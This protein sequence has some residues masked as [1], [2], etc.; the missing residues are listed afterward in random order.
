MICEASWR[1]TGGAFSDGRPLFSRI[2]T[3]YLFR[4]SS[5]QYAAAAARGAKGFVY[6][7]THRL[8]PGIADVLRSYGLPAVCGNETCHMEE[9]PFVFD[10]NPSVAAPDV[11]TLKNI[12]FTAEEAAMASTF[13]DYWT[14]FATTGDPNAGRSQPVQWPS[15]DAKA[16]HNVVLTTKDD[17]P[18]GIHTES[19]AGLCAFWDTV[20]YL[21]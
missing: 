6:R 21:H 17:D 9:L 10:W 12:S 3:D 15:W 5:E 19:S 20:G 7:Y 16:R 18:V 14:A 4:C 1:E 11:P 8:S 13:G 2:I